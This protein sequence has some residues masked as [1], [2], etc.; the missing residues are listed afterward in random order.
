ME[1]AELSKPKNNPI[2]DVERAASGRKALFP[3]G[4]GAVGGG[5]L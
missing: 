2:R 3:E 4:S 1:K 5:G